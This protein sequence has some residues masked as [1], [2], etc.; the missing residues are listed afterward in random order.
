M[1]DAPLEKCNGSMLGTNLYV[2]ARLNCI[3]LNEK[4]CSKW[5]YKIEM[6]KYY[7]TKS[8]SLIVLVFLCKIFA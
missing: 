8:D 7:P 4:N 5:F 6:I 2:R 1:I 3:P